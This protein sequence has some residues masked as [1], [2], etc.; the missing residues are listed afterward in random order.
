MKKCLFPQDKTKT[1]LRIESYWLSYLVIGQVLIPEPLTIDERIS[2]AYG[3]SG[4]HVVPYGW[5][6]AYPDYR[7]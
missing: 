7:G 3:R 4:L 2:C 1:R 6:R 5:G